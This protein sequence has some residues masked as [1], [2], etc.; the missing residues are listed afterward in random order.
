MRYILL[1]ALSIL[2]SVQVG[3]SQCA[4][5]NPTGNFGFFPST[6]LLAC[7]DRGQYYDETFYLENVDSFVIGGFAIKMLELRIDSIGNVPCNL[8]WVTNKGSNS[9]GTGET[10][11]IR[12]FGQTND[13]AGQYKLEI[14][15]TL[16]L[17]VLGEL[18]GE[19]N[20][21][22]KDLEDLINTSLGV[23][24]R[25]FIRVKE[26]I[27]NCP[28]VDFDTLSPLLRR[29]AASC[30]IAGLVEAQITGDTVICRGTT[31]QLALSLSNMTNPS[32]EWTPASAVSNPFTNSTDV[33]LANSGYITAVVTDTA[34]TG[35]VY[36]DRVWVTVDT[37]NPI[38]SAVAP[39]INGRNIKLESS[40]SNSTAASWTLG[41]QTIKT[42]ESILHT[43]AADGVYPISLTVTNSCGTDVYYDTLFIGNV[44]ISNIAAPSLQCTIYPN[45]TNDKNIK[46]NVSGLQLMEE[47]TVLVTDLAGKTV[48]QPQ[49][50]QFNPNSAISLSVVGLPSGVYVFQVKTLHSIAVN[51]LIIY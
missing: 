17:T 11:C 4:P 18:Q 31:G 47:L 46:L 44:G 24:F 28:A 27:A 45:P 3:R 42:G 9:F 30:P 26:P 40:S 1:L 49:T 39:I 8:N 51:K 16:R 5:N 21:I 35:A 22:I 37:A 23:D 29:S 36:I 33:A 20:T 48:L 10:G 6:E 13:T 50:F 7:V 43:Y 19:I 12:I 15:V 38:A 34:N 2:A 14:F 32:V 25:Y 41:D